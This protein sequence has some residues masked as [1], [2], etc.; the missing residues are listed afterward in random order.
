M[1]LLIALLI[2]VGVATMT[3]LK[4]YS[5]ICITNN[6]IADLGG[7]RMSNDVQTAKIEIDGYL[8]KLEKGDV[9]FSEET[10]KEVVNRLPQGKGSDP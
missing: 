7:Y 4:S 10:L 6:L 5:D 8:S 1:K 3:P 2:L 9:V